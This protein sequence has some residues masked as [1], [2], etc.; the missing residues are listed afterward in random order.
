[1]SVGSRI[2]DY[3]IIGDGRSAALVHRNGS[4]DWLCWPR[5]DSPSLFGRLLDSGGGHWRITPTLPALMSR[6]Y[7]DGTNVLQT[8][9]T[10][11][12]GSIDVVDFMPAASEEDK[13]RM[14]WPEQELIRQVGCSAGEVEIA[15][16]FQPRPDFG[17]AA[18]TMRDGGVFGLRLDMGQWL[19]TLRGDA[20]WRLTDKGATGRVRL[21][22]GE[23]ATFSLS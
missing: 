6:R 3:A 9:L 10:T 21:R 15:V 7:I 23:Q 8:R 20:K 5:F 12:S 2:A 13:R 16:D 18:F 4:I 14:L 17:R 19:L 1:M 22:T 11:E